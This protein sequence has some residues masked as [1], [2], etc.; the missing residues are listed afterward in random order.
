M[1]LFL[2]AVVAVEVEEVQLTPSLLRRQEGRSVFQGFAQLGDLQMS[3]FVNLNAITL[4][5][6]QHRTRGSVLLAE[7][8]RMSSKTF[9]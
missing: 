4:R 9:P 5:T 3:V 8:I 7:S 1:A 2:V 6:S